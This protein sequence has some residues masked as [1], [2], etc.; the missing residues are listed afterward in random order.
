M[1]T[2]APSPETAEAPPPARSK[3]PLVLIVTMLAAAVGGGAVG[4]FVVAPRV[5][6]APAEAAAEPPPAEAEIAA[7]EIFSVG[8]LIVNPAGSLGTRFLMVTVGIAATPSTGLARLRKLEIP[9][10]DAITT[11]L[12]GQTLEE[13]TQPGARD[14]LR[15]A[16]QGA[17]A[18]LAGSGVAL[19][20][21]LP[22]FVIQ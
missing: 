6:A 22:Q 10:R 20:I 21:Y 13:L 1:S 12:E 16:L 4:A 7:G 9:V 5:A 15:Q 11:V 3:G 14:S 2:P 19:R 17:L 18:P 8:N